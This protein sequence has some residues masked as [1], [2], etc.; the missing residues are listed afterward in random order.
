LATLE[1]FDEGVAEAA[2]ASIEI[3]QLLRSLPQLGEEAGDAEKGAA[4]A[5]ILAVRAGHGDRGLPGMLG[6]PADRLEQQRPTGDGLAPGFPLRSGPQSA[7]AL[8]LLAIR[9]AHLL[10]R[11]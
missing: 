10:A 11:V 3:S 7:A 2:V 6:L 4:G 5:L 9:A 1:V 8:S